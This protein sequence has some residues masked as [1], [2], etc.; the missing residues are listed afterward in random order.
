MLQIPTD[1][2]FIVKRAAPLRMKPIKFGRL[3]SGLGTASM[4]NWA[5]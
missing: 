4:A 1:S 3:A 2:L 5:N